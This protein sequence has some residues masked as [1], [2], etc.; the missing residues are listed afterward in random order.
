MKEPPSSE[1]PYRGPVAFVLSSG[2]SMGAAQ[3]GML[4]ALVEHHV[5]PDLVVGSSIGAVNGAGFAE[6][7]TPEGVE[8][9]EEVWHSLDPR[10]LLPR[11]RLAPARALTRRGEAINP[12][13]GLLQVVQR[14]F[15]ALTFE[16]LKVP[17]HC[18]ATEVVTARETWFDS[19][20]LPEAV[21][22]S[23]AIPAIYPAVEIEGRRYVDGGVVVDVPIRRA[24]DLGART[25][26]VLGLARLNRPWSEPRR[27]LHAAIEAYWVARRHR[28]QR[29]LDALPD[30][31]TVHLLEVDPPP[32]I[33]FHDVAYT[34]HLIDTGHETASA[35]LESL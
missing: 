25:L 23:T 26:Y 12:S 1:T 13:D 18:V 30:E 6:S 7:P 20:P 10:E 2:G 3:V 22:A 21:L 9:L 19:G 32:G 4:K 29:D 15:S 8:H 11:R 35:Y 34:T 33:R 14:T 27:P 31:V 17:F 28:F 5:L 24:A 16:E